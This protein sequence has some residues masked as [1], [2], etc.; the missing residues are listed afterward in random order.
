MPAVTLTGIMTVRLNATAR[1][2]QL[3]DV[4]V[5]VFAKNGYHAASMNDVAVAAGVTKPVV[6][7]HFASKKD[8]YIAL[9]DEVGRRLLTRISK[10]TAEAVDGRTQ[11]LAGFSAYFH[12]VAD[13]HDA[14]LLLFGSGPRSDDDFADA[15]R[16]VTDGVAS[17]IASL[18]TVD[19]SAE[20]RETLAH[21]IVGMAESA[22]RK[23]IDSGTSFE[24]D[25]I[26]EQ[27]AV[28][29]WSGLRG[30]GR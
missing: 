7:Q 16:R 2:E 12:W 17:A 26:A 4:A 10:A 11:T 25:R 20:H 24:P 13:D 8:L 22:S 1:R 18:I 30:L 15:V 27:L 6:Y 3:V 14:F 19:I 29:A 23:L 28:L 21:A 9:L 5:G